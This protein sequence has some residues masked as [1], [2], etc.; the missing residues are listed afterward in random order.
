MVVGRYVAQVYLVQSQKSLYSGNI[1]SADSSALNSLHFA[2][3]DDA[4]RTR[5]VIAAT[6]VRQLER[7]AT[8]TSPAFQ[9]QVQS[10]LSQGIANAQAA[11][12][13]NAGSY[14]N[15]LALGNLYQIAIP[16]KVSGSYVATQ[17]TYAKA[18]S[19]NPVS[20]LILYTQAQ[21]AIENR[22]YADA[23]TFLRKAIALKPNYTQAIFLLSQ[24][25]V[26]LG[27]AKE[28]LRAAQSAA[29]FSP[30]NPYV[31]FQVGVLREATGN[32]SSAIQV[33]KRAVTINPKYANAH[34]FLAVA[35]ANQKDYSKAIAEL[36]MIVTLSSGNKR[37]ITPIIGAL[38]KGI[39]PFRKSPGKSFSSGTPIRTSS[40][41]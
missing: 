30:N 35:Y 20:P 15:W 29:Y 17:S 8:S 24:V 23:N 3:S 40:G 6:A 10:I 27:K 36:K 37:T 31:L 33:L 26:Q 4:Y 14:L 41:K 32:M 39:N 13:I 18:T 12:R 16:L 7:T 2:K 1:I 34:Y 5:A 11:I 28:A 21:A 25:D 22:S 19:L 9:K 38:E